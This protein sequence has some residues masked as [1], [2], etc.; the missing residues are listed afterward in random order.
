MPMVL[1]SPKENGQRSN[2][3]IT[4]SGLK[5]TLD[6]SSL[7][8]DIKGFQEGRTLW[9]RKVGAKVI[10]FK[11]QVEF[12]THEGVS[13]TKIGF[14]YQYKN[15]TYSESSFYIECPQQLIHAK[16]LVLKKNL[17]HEKE[18]ENIVKGVVCAP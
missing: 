1:F 17:D 3:S 15:K 18:F 6:K 8:K 11:S 13:V 12:K 10:S 4:P 9:T 5:L 14:D 7:K 2:L 16:G